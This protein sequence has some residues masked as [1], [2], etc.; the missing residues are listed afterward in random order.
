MLS[1][2]KRS[3]R[4]YISKYRNAPDLLFINERLYQKLIQDPEFFENSYFNKAL[5]CRV[6]FGC[7]IISVPVASDFYNF[8]EFKDLNGRLGKDPSL[9]IEKRNE[10]PTI[11]PYS[12]GPKGPP[13]RII[14][15]PIYIIDSFNDYV[16][17]GLKEKMVV[18]ISKFYQEQSKAMKHLPG[19]WI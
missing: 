7:F 13:T 6:V 10:E 18:D 1:N 2:I 15:I 3:Y 14:E 17:R 5:K 12:D 9:L 4:E 16:G 19:N 8:Y 11:L